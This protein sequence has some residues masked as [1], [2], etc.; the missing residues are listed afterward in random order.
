MQGLVG[1]GLDAFIHARLGHADV[2]L[3]YENILQSR[4][5]TVAVMPEIIQDLR[6]SVTWAFLD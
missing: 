2:R 5:Y 6:L 1:N 3:S 4:W